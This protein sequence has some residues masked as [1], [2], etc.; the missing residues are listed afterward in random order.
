MSTIP[1]IEAGQTWQTR[2]RSTILIDEI[3]ENNGAF[4]VRS[5]NGYWQAN[6]KYWADDYNHGKDLIKLVK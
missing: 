4:P 3:V 5:G 1:K 2:N 6:G